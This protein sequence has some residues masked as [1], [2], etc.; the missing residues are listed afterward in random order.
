MARIALA[1]PADNEVY[2]FARARTKRMP[3]GLGYVAAALE[4]AGHDVKIT[5]GSLYDLTVSETANQILACDPEFAGIGCTTPLYHQAVAIAEEIKQKSPST[6]VIF[7]GPHVSA[8]PEATLQTSKA[9][10]VCIGEAEE[11][12]PAIVKCVLKGLHPGEI[13]GIAYNLPGM[14]G[15]T[16]EYRLR[17]KQPRNETVVPIDLDKIPIPARHL[18]DGDG[19]VDYARGIRQAQAGAMFTRGCVGK[20]TFCGAAGT[21][22]RYRNLDN[23]LEEL[24]Q[25][26]GMGI[27][28]VF[29]HD[30]SYTHNRNRVLDLCRRIVD[31]G[32][33]LEISVQL[34]LDQ[35]DEEICEALYASGV[36]YVAPGIESGNEEMIK[37]IGK[38][39][40]ESKEHMRTKVRILQKF[41]WC[42]RCTFVMG[43]PDETERQIMDTI[44][45]AVELEASESTFCLITPY[46]DSPLW[47]MAKARGLVHDKMDFSKFIYYHTIGCNLSAV[48]TERLL[49]L[50]NLA[51]QTVKNPGYSFA[52]EV[53]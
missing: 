22:V 24:R 39:P 1:Y 15:H 18:F 7:G 38:G 3:L 51:Y 19:Y 42:I 16:K 48:P 6:V 34:R 41:P 53:G 8:L 43:M 31:E 5:D 26:V 30:D 37:A 9:D 29:V 11:S 21:A 35:I 33:K 50:Q 45:F 2:N 14:S 49:E 47:P 28:A 40:K 27:G 32:I 20:C 13:P 12:A 36:R 46:P 52:E 44:N 25:I 17:M 10:F 4:R 23:V